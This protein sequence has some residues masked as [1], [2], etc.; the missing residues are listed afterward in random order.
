M[1]GGGISA[2]K[3]HLVIWE[4]LQALKKNHLLTSK[5]LYGISVRIIFFFARRMMEFLGMTEILG[6]LKKEKHKLLWQR[7]RAM[8]IKNNFS[9]I[10]NET[11]G[12]SHADL[13]QNWNLL[14]QKR[15]GL[16]GLLIHE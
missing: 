16:N 11:K 12:I 13:S 1:D 4:S 2:L 6:K 15:I 7:S 5:N 14:P 9:P 10:L 8:A 3:E